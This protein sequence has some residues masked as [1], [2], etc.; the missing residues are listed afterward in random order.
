MTS[1]LFEW[2]AYNHIDSFNST[3]LLT[4]YVIIRID[5]KKVAYSI[6]VGFFSIKNEL[7]S[8]IYCLLQLESEMLVSLTY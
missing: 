2:T 1:G 3:F 4:K 6:K 5:P 8:Q 7:V